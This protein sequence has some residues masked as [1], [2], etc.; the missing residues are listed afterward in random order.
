MFSPEK[1]DTRRGDEGSHVARTSFCNSNVLARR[2][3]TSR[4]W[5]VHLLVVRTST[6]VKDIVR[7]R[8]PPPFIFRTSSLSRFSASLFAMSEEKRRFKRFGE[9]S[10][11]LPRSRSRSRSRFSSLPACPPA[12]G[13]SHDRKREQKDNDCSLRARRCTARCATCRG[14]ATALE[15]TRSA[16]RC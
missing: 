1:L 14:H 13:E 5:K 9:E 8:D 3:V 15:A 2:K 16:T 12:Y 10:K 4:R 7:A 6:I 11:G